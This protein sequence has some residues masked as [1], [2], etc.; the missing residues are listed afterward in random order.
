MQFYR[1]IDGTTPN[2]HEIRAQNPNVGIPDAP[3]DLTDLGYEPVG[4][5]DKPEHAD[6]HIAEIS[7]YKKIDGVWTPVWIVRPLTQ[8]ELV[9]PLEISRRQALQELRSHG[10]TY[11]MIHAEVSTIE[12]E[13][14]RDMALI[15][16]SDSQVFERHRPLVIQIGT[17]LGLNLDMLFI[18]AAKR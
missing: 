3:E 17:R 1:L 10:I 12:D 5:S 15:E 2:I 11:D 6:D 7:E 16:L 9:V 13:V 4:N 8:D 18:N 14:T